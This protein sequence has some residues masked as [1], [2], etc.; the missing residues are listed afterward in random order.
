MGIHL[1]ASTRGAGPLTLLLA[2]GIALL[3]PQVAHLP[4]KKAARARCTITTSTTTTTTTTTWTTCRRT[5]CCKT[6]MAHCLVT[7]PNSLRGCCYQRE[8]CVTRSSP[9]PS[10]TSFSSDNLVWADADGTWR[11]KNYHHRNSHK[12]VRRRGERKHRV[13]SSEDV[14]SSAEFDS[15][16]ESDGRC[17]TADTAADTTTDFFV[18]AG[19]V[20]RGIRARS[21]RS[22]VFDFGK[23]QLIF[24]YYLPAKSRPRRYDSKSRC[25]RTLLNKSAM[26][27]A[28]S[29]MTLHLNVPVLIGFQGSPGLIH[30]L[31]L[32]LT[33]ST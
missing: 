17:G 12:D 10:T 32:G 25:C 26:F 16:F 5:R 14:S 30:R 2:L 9:S 20:P 24:R 28:R 8:R 13:S 4:P 15:A 11:S 27:S 1:A 23:H 7:L 31:Q 19:D 3:P 18:L 33:K 22:V 21:A 29:R 6:S